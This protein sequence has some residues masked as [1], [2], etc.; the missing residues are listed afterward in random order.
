MM[1]F[2]KPITNYQLPITKSFFVLFISF[3]AGLTTCYFATPTVFGGRDQGAIATAAIELVKNKSFSFSA[4]LS[5]ELFQKYG[6]GKALNYPG[7]DYTRE[8]KLITRFPKAY[9]AYLAVFYAALGIKGLQYA[10]FL[11]LALFL[12]LFWLTLRQFFSEKVSFLGFLV[13][14]T[15]FPFLWFAKYTLTEIFMLFLVWT[16]IYFLISFR[17][18]TSKACLQVSLAAFALST[19]TRIEGMAFFALAVIYILLLDRKKIIRLPKNFPK[20]IFLSTLFLAIIYVFLNFPA[21]FDSLKNIAKA[22]LPNST[23]DSAPSPSLYLRLLELFFNYNILVYLV[24]GLAGIFLIVRKMKENWSKPEFLVI[25]ILFPS[26]FYLVSP[27]ISLDDPWMLRRFVFSVFPV[28]IFYTIYFLHHLFRHKIFLFLTLV[29]L[30]VANIFISWRFIFLSENKDLLSQVEEISQKFG[31]NDLILVD[32]LAVG[33]GFS[34]L[35]E[36]LRTIF[37]KKA[38][39]FF[40]AEDLNFINRAKYSNIYLITPEINEEKPNW[41]ADIE[42]IP[43]GLATIS[44]NFLE[45]SQERFGLPINMEYKGKII[46]W[47]VK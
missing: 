22:F 46:F 28:L 30:I 41:Y 5:E 13:A 8:G 18:R 33:S 14:I 16:G 31:P 4:P 9:I 6:P 38:V 40:N 2:F 17:R 3:L 47:R 20:F 39:Y 37:G 27:L 19:L 12:F 15:F 42:K 23:K 26:F 29:V 10:N 1:S 24:L 11:P 21:L 43:A 35:S 25:F 44:N 45:P 34:L 32:R 7:F 36:P